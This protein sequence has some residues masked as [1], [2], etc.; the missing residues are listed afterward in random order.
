[1]KNAKS[2]YI[3]EPR[4]KAP[5]YFD[6]Q[7]ANIP[8]ALDKID[9]N[10]ECSKNS[11]FTKFYYAI[12][13]LLLQY[14]FEDVEKNAYSK[15]LI[16]YK[17]SQ[18]EE[19]LS[20]GMEILYNINELMQKQN[21]TENLDPSTFPDHTPMSRFI[22]IMEE[23]YGLLANNILKAAETIPPKTQLEF[24]RVK[25]MLKE[26]VR[27]GKIPEEI[28][29]KMNENEKKF[30]DLFFTTISNAE[31]VLN[32]GNKNIM[33]EYIAKCLLYSICKENLRDHVGSLNYRIALSFASE[34]YNQSMCRSGF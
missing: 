22:L 19:R 25:K 31:G 23:L 16:N 34:N 33:Q 2:P 13:T 27:L 17:E 7:N 11:N 10:F 24:R 20:L 9:V 26:I 18:N 15:W 12:D 30:A 8:P 1:M 28:Y 21:N 29:T 32:D 4:Q 6:L 5:T 3:I 14:P